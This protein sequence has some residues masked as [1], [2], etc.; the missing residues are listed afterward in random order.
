ML[1]PGDVGD[2]PPPQPVTNVASEAPAARWQAPVQNCRREMGVYVSDI[3]LILV[4]AC[5]AALEDQTGKI[6]ATRNWADFSAVWATC[7]CRPITDS[8]M[9]A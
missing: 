9:D 3:A 2:E 6:E 4:R 8:G 5:S 1:P 7:R